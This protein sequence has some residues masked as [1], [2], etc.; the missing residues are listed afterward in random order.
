M[1]A[2]SP[3]WWTKAVPPCSALQRLAQ[4]INTLLIKLRLLQRTVWSPGS[5]FF[6]LRTSFFK[7]LVLG[8]M[9][10][11]GEPSD[12]L[13]FPGQGPPLRGGAALLGPTQEGPSPR[14]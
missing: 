1:P 6:F 14:L 13:S 4:M 7:Y 2:E 8:I 5:F 3:S 9:W 12:P 11:L 10:A